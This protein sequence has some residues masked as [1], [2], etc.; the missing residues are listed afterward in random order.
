MRGAFAGAREDVRCRPV[1]EAKP[2]GKG[3]EEEEGPARQEDDNRI[4]Q[5]SNYVSEA[6]DAGSDPSGDGHVDAAAG[7]GNSA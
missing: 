2:R 6:E 1:Q 7:A 4:Q 3:G 5:E